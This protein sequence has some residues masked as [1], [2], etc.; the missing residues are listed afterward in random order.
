M[1]HDKNIHSEVFANMSNFLDPQTRV[2][3][4]ENEC[5][6]EALASL[7]NAAVMLEEDKKFALA[8]AVNQIMERIPQTLSEGN[9]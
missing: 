4:A 3:K 5:V 1:K 8:E 2:K 9:E 6:L 7:D